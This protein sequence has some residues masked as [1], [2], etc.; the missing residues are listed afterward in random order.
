M[1]STNNIFVKF[2]RE[3]LRENGLE[4]N[5]KNTK[6]VKTDGSMCWGF[7]DEKQICVAKNNP[8]W[9]EVLA[10]EYSHFIQWKRG[11][12]LY[13]KCFGPTNNYAD[14][15]EDWL[16]GKDFDS[17]RVKKAFETYRS[18]ERECEKI[19]VKVMQ[20]HGIKFDLERYT[21]ES[22]CH[23]YMYHYMERRRKSSFNNEPTKNWRIVRQMPSSFRVQSHKILPK[24]IDAVMDSLL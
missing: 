15:V 17:R 19:T 2:V 14:V 6:F 9:I 12:E 4:L 10:H 23:I 8:R 21:Q 18:M 7:F 13:K 22:N 5:L 1:A 3:T 11:T 16:I 24:E 20:R